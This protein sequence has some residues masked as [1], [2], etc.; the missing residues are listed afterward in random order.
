M[1]EV[2][3]LAVLNL[4]YWYDGVGNVIALRDWTNDNQVLWFTYD[5]LDRLTHGRDTTPH[6]SANL[7]MTVTAT[8]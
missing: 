5:S 3:N 2:R 6:M 8:A 4:N 7:C 1:R